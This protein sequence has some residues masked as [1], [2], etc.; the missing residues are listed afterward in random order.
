MA[1]GTYQ[2]R[3]ADVRL[4]GELYNYMLC[5]SAPVF[6]ALY[7]LVTAGHEDEEVAGRLDPADDYFRIRWAGSHRLPTA[8]ACLAMSAMFDGCFAADSMVRLGQ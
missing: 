2:K 1:P 6:E 3:M 8:A 7:L 4:L 5:N